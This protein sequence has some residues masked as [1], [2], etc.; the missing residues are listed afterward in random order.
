M[1]D[2]PQGSFTLPV[3][4]R[5]MEGRICSIRAAPSLDHG[6][7][8]LMCQRDCPTNRLPRSPF[9]LVDCYDHPLQTVRAVVDQPD[10][11]RGVP[12]GDL[13]EPQ[14][15]VGEPDA[16]Q[17]ETPGQGADHDLDEVGLFQNLRLTSWQ[18]GTL[19]EPT[20]EKQAPPALCLIP[21]PCPPIAKRP[22][23]HPDNEHP[24]RPRSSVPGE[25]CI[26]PTFAQK[27]KS[28]PLL[29]EPPAYR[30]WKFFD[31]TVGEMPIP[32]DLR[33]LD[34]QI[35]TVR[36]KPAQFVSDALIELQTLLPAGTDLDGLWRSAA[37]HIADALGPLPERLPDDLHDV[38]AFRAFRVV[39]EVLQVRE[40]RAPVFFGGSGAF[41]TTT[42]TTT[43]VHAFGTATCPPVLRLVVFRG[44]LSVSIDLTSPYTA[45]DEAMA[46]LLQHFHLQRPFHAGSTV[47][48]ARALPPQLGYL[49]E[50]VFVINDEH[51]QVPVVW[52]AR[53]IGGAMVVHYVPWITV[54]EFVMPQ[55]WRSQ[56]WTSAVNGSPVHLV[57]RTVA[58]GDFIQPHWGDRPPQAV[59]QSLVLD[60]ARVLRGIPSTADNILYPRIGLRHGDVLDPARFEFPPIPNSSEIEAEADTQP[61]PMPNEPTIAEAAGR[62]EPRSPDEE[63]TISQHHDPVAMLQLQSRLFSRM[64]QNQQESTFPTQREV[65][66]VDGQGK[67]APHGVIV[68]TP[69][70]RRSL[71]ETTPVSR[72][73]TLILEDLI[74]PISAP[75]EAALHFPTTSEMPE[76]L[77]E[78]FGL[79]AFCLTIPKQVRLHRAAQRLL[80]NLTTWDQTSRFDAA[81][82]FIDGSY[83][84][85]QA[86]WAI[87]GFV[88]VS[89]VWQWAGYLGAVLDPKFEARSSYE[90]ELMAQLAAHCAAAQCQAPV[91]IYYDSTAAAQVAGG[92][93]A[94]GGNN[95]IADALV[96]AAAYLRTA[97]KS[98]LLQHTPS[99]QGNPANELADSLAQAFLTAAK[100]EVHDVFEPLRDSILARDLA[101]LWVRAPR[102]GTVPPVDQW[103]DS[104]PARRVLPGRVIPK[105]AE[106]APP[107][108]AS[109]Q[110]TLC[111]ELRL[112][113]YNVLSAKAALQ[114]QCLQTAFRQGHFSALA[115]QETKY[116]AEP[117]QVVDGVL[118]LSGPCQHGEEGVAL[119]F[120]VASEGVPWN[121]AHIAT[122][123]AHARLLTALVSL[124]GLKL[125]FFSGHARPSTATADQIDEFWDLVRQRLRALPPDTAPV[126]LVDANARFSEEAGCLRPLNRN[127][128]HWQQIL[129]DYG[130]S[131]TGIRASDGAL[132]RTWTSPCGQGACLDFIGFPST[133]TQALRHVGTVELVDEFTGIDHDPLMAC[134]QLQFTAQPQ[135]KGPYDLEAMHTGDG[136]ATVRKI[137]ERAPQITWPVGV[138]EHVFQLNTYFQEQLQL[139]FACPRARPRHPALSATTWS[140]LRAKRGL[141]RAFRRKRHLDE[142]RLVFVILSA[143]KAQTSGGDGPP[144]QRAIEQI[145]AADIA[146]ASYGKAMRA[147]QARIR[148]SF[149]ADTAN[150]TRCMWKEARAGGPAEIAKLLR[151]VLKAGRSY[152]PQRTA[153]ALSVGNETVTGP[154]EVAEVFGRTFAVAEQAHAASFVSLQCREPTA[155][156]S[157]KRWLV[158][159]MPSVVQL[160]ASF[161]SLK[162]RRAAGPSGIPADFYAADPLGSALLHAPVVLKS[163]TR[164]RI[165][166]LWGGC[167]SRPLLK[168][169]KRPDDPASYRAIALQEPASKAAHKSLRP[170]LCSCFEGI[171]LDGV[172]GARPH[173]ALAVPALT[174]QSAISFAQTHKRSISVIFFDGVAAFYATARSSLFAFDKNDLEQEL[175]RGPFN[176]EAVSAFLAFLPEGGALATAGVNPATIA[177]LQ[178]SMSHTWYTTLLDSEQVYETSKGTVPGAPLADILFQ[179]VFHAAVAALNFLLRRH[180]LSLGVSYGGCDHTAEPCSWLDDLT[181]IIQ[182]DEASTL[183]DATTKAAQLTHQCMGMIGI[184]VNY[185]PNK[186][187]ALMLWKGKGSKRARDQV[188]LDH[189]GLVP[190]GL[191]SDCP[192]WLRC[193]DCYAHLGTARA[194]SASASLDVDRRAGLARATY[195]PLRRRLLRNPELSVKERCNLLFSIVLTSFTYG[196]G[197]WPFASES[198]QRQFASKYMMFLRGACR[199]ILGVPC[200]RLDIEQTC[201]LLGALTP[202]EALIDARVR[203]FTQVVERGS[204]FLRA[205]VLSE[206]TWLNAVHKDIGVLGQVLQSPTLLSLQSSQTVDLWEA[207]TFTS[208]DTSR[209]L[210]RFK[211]RCIESRQALRDTA[212]RKASLHQW[213]SDNGCTFVRT[214]E[215]GDPVRSFPCTD[216]GLCFRSAA[217]CAAHRSALHLHKS[218]ASFGFGTACQICR[219][220]YWTR[221]RLRDHLRRSSRCAMVFEHCD[222]VEDAPTQKDAKRCALPVADLIG[223]QPWWATLVPSSAKESPPTPTPPTEGHDIFDRF[224]GC[225]D[226]NLFLLHR[227]RVVENGTG[228]EMQ[229][230]F[231]SQDSGTAEWRLANSVAAAIGR[232]ELGLFVQ[233]D[234]AAL[235]CS[236]F[237]LFGPHRAIL[238]AGKEDLTVL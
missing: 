39:S 169:G 78:P 34:L 71:P 83:K 35:R 222:I 125:M 130:L 91:A 25:D 170:H 210:K 236:N 230:F 102:C 138:D 141:R 4:F 118:R 216:C 55:T 231:E 128:R 79:H 176:Q 56:R 212:W 147:L 92:S 232:E 226:Y 12:A 20:A 13:I 101:W 84:D 228:V 113:S 116:A 183:V 160:A 29:V 75:I 3:D 149:R 185:G 7:L 140:L 204:P 213:L 59:P 238:L 218:P 100:P 178:A 32:W 136:R 164:S 122:T 97:H 144:L 61:M 150:F 143:W 233:N 57:P 171:A 229:H 126:L 132:L 163:L 38:Q 104:F 112:V 33:G 17:I 195:Q 182:A 189:N 215:V 180:G 205:L 62:S 26:V 98:P 129:T 190:L 193:T 221:D 46:R 65:H 186:T 22:P 54:C 18:V 95:A 199:P 105:P 47:T 159:Q 181:V 137:L 89:G 94:L 207:W 119:W 1:R 93:Q 30:D 166:V 174:V 80:D 225:M 208:K 139:H 106:F 64:A 196:L 162:P 165:P 28:E 153:V 121:R 120:N 5:Q 15:E 111:C 206:G 148:A 161:A 63:A 50:V 217:A 209:L 155:Q 73:K 68:P 152:K 96:A 49:Q 42:V 31:R 88:L 90:P 109:P 156:G 157:S 23:L 202:Q 8:A 9:G 51:G 43:G 48:L 158:E 99:H 66:T 36:H 173:F 44:D 167:L 69:F 191:L 19:S 16:A 237:V 172:G 197:T 219:K 40:L 168:P 175:L 117:A 10:Y 81:M 74:G 82:F 227:K 21:D 24:S 151:S 124:P 234:L 187:E 37:L 127:A 103:G 134:F 184:E 192:R 52:D 14:D 142:K 76:L 133:W 224:R 53:G 60:L 67:K 110:N 223:P 201:S 211:R 11:G 146:A 154:N 27:L 85:E 145:K 115:L 135:R 41:E 123:F 220:Q 72:P 107:L 45:F 87:A 70:G 188:L 114:R 235:I 214:G 86:S 203:T 2:F 177:T 77:F 58:P 198:E 194:T 200:R 6:E 179:Y 131:H 108:A